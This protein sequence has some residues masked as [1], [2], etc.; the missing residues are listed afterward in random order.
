MQ[1]C[2]ENFSK[3]TC[4]I[5]LQTQYESSYFSSYPSYFQNNIQHVCVE[6]PKRTH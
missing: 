6:L 2:Y 5:T 3:H 4:F 1:N